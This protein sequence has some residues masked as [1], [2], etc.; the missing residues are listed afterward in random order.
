MAIIAGQGASLD[1]LGVATRLLLLSA[2][3]VSWLLFVGPAVATL[4]GRAPPENPPAHETS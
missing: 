1:V 3:L 2:L 4:I